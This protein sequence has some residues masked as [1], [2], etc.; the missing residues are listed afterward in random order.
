MDSW[1]LLFCKPRQEARAKINLQ[2]QGIEAFFSSSKN[3]KTR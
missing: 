2:N 1:Y 3:R